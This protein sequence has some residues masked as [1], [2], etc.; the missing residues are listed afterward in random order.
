VPD[1]QDSGITGHWIKQI[2]LHLR[3]FCTEYFKHTD[4][5]SPHKIRMPSSNNSICQQ[6]LHGRNAVLHY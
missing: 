1:Y 3:S 2:L 4:Q 6:I 5:L